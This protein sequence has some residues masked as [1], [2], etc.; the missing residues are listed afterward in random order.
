MHRISLV[1]SR[2]SS[3]KCMRLTRPND[4]TWCMQ[5]ISGLLCS[6]NRWISTG[7]LFLK[8]SGSDWKYIKF[9]PTILECKFSIFLRSLKGFMGWFEKIFASHSQQNS[10]YW[11]FG[12]NANL[13][14]RR[15]IRYCFLIFF[16]IWCCW[17]V[18]FWS[19]IQVLFLVG[20][21]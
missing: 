12:T 16:F 9:F 21:M 19:K 13:D 17:H 3:R 5:T 8:M 15:L 20:G 7:F 11:L 14:F 4:V 1:T 10:W 6:A 18:L 2:I